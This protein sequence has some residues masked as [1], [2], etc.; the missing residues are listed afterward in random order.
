MQLQKERRLSRGSVEDLPVRAKVKLGK[1]FGR[2]GWE[3]GESWKKRGRKR[4][5][6]GKA[7]KII[8]G[9]GP[10]NDNIAGQ[11]E[12][13]WINGMKKGKHGFG[14]KK[15]LTLWGGKEGEEVLGGLS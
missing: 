12:Y 7:G 10:S 11:I 6:G 3:M 14:R 13:S 8:P 1:Q 15:V 9:S 5:R 4:Q 2:Q